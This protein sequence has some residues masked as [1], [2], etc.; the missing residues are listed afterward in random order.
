MF[1]APSQ[2][3]LLLKGERVEGIVTARS[4]ERGFPGA[5]NVSSS[6]LIHVFMLQTS[7]KLYL[8]FVHYSECF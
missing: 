6:A 5:S 1:G 4:Q 8:S 3:C 2:Q 7:K